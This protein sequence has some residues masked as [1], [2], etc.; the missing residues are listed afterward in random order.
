MAVLSRT[1]EGGKVRYEIM[2]EGWPAN[3][4]SEINRSGRRL[5]RLV[6]WFLSGS[7][8]LPFYVNYPHDL[9]DEQADV[10]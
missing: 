1:D 10:S 8:I 4:P 5:H 6:D 7:E 9:I 2:H 3:D